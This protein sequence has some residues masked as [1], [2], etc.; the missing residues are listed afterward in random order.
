MFY[1]KLRSKSTTLAADG[2][3]RYTC[4]CGSIDQQ[5]EHVP[6]TNFQVQCLVMCMCLLLFS[7][8][9]SYR[10]IYGVKWG[11]SQ[12]SQLPVRKHIEKCLY[13]EQLYKYRVIVE[14]WA[15]WFLMQIKPVC[16]HVK[17]VDRSMAILRSCYYRHTSW[18]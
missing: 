5:L 13:L 9:S 12:T 1:P 6:A 18:P 2:Q 11:S 3:F 16:M 7:S 4:V 14:P 15:S 8:T 10:A 17:F